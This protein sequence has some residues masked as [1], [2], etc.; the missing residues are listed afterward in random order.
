MLP[1]LLSVLLAQDLTDSAGKAIKDAK[2]TQAEVTSAVSQPAKDLGLVR[3]QLPLSIQRAAAAPF[4][5]KTAQSC[6]AIAA[7]ILA[8]DKDL[9]PDVDAPAERSETKGLAGDFIRGALQLPFS[10]IVRRISGASRREAAYR[11]AVAAGMVRR[12]YLKGRASA[13]NCIA[14]AQPGPRE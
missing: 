5:A 2:P 12:G 4:D 8:L 13:L 9:G 1:L 14:D 10:G 7:E 11:R 3:D 6:S